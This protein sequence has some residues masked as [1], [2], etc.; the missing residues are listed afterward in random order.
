MAVPFPIPASKF[1][2][3]LYLRQHLLFLFWIIA[4]FVGVTGR[5]RVIL[6]RISPITLISKLRKLKLRKSDKT[7]QFLED[8]TPRVQILWLL[9]EGFPEVPQSSSSACVLS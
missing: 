9:G 4:T 1:P 5:L 6:I 2:V 3:S 7:V 8:L